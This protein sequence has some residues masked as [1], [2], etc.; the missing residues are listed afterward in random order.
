ML[1]QTISKFIKTHLIL[2]IYLEVQKP[3]LLHRLKFV[4]NNFKKHNR[5]NFISVPKYRRKNVVAHPGTDTSYN[6]ITFSLDK[7][8]DIV[9]FALDNTF[10]KLGH[11]ILQQIDGL[12]MGD[13]MS[14]PLAFI[15]VAYDEH[16]FS[17][18]KKPSCMNNI[19][20]RLFR[21]ADD[22][23]RL[24]AMKSL[25]SSIIKKIDL[26]ITNNIYEH[27]IPIKNLTLE[28]DFNTSDKFL[29]SDIVIYNDNHDIKLTY[30][31][32]NSSMIETNFQEVGRLYNCHDNMLMKV[33]INAISPDPYTCI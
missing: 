23:F 16:V 19:L 17:I 21:Y 6:F 25:D 9:T 12:P 22:I 10:F 7:I 8:L 4:L 26:Y 15:Y 11:Y 3:Q 33:K 1:N 32:K 28:Q 14:P 2:K 27:D 18:C 13:P 31:N 30:H 20:V 5:T 24:L 29:D